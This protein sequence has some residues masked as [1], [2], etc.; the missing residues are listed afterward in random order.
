MEHAVHWL[1]PLTLLAGVV[2][3]SDPCEG[4][5]FGP[6]PF[7]Q[8]LKVTD[9]ETGGAIAGLAVTGKLHVSCQEQG[10]STNCFGGGNAEDLPVGSYVLRITAPGYKDTAAT[11]SVWNPWP[12]N[13]DSCFPP[14]CVS[15]PTVEVGMWPIKAETGCEYYVEKPKAG[16]LPTATCDDGCCDEGTRIPGCC[17]ETAHCDDGDPCTKDTCYVSLKVCNNSSIEGC[18]V[19]P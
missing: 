7:Q 18:C 11:V 2:G 1:I 3:C 5:V 15:I 12:E 19:N 16:P 13:E 9:A 6:C 17:L 8:V 10:A 4:F 14:P